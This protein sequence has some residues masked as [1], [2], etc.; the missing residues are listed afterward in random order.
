MANG[1][2]IT[3]DDTLPQGALGDTLHA[4]VVPAQDERL[5]NP[6]TLLFALQLVWPYVH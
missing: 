2:A 5:A 1:E 3:A 6:V 4:L